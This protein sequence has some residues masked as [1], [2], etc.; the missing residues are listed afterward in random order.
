MKRKVFSSPVEV[1]DPPSYNGEDFDAFNKLEKEWE[2]KL[3][4]WCIPNG[5]SKYKGDLF[6][7]PAG[8]GYARYF[9]FSISPLVLVHVKTGDAW[10]IPEVVERGLTSKYVKQV[11][12]SNKSLGS[13][14]NG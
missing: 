14:F 3:K 6:T 12:D 4:E 10:S 9:V 5:S 1:G 11:V 7:Y 8:D 13:I 2:Q